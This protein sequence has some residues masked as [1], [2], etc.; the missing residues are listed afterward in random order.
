[1]LASE[2]ALRQFTRVMWYRM[3]FLDEVIVVNKDNANEVRRDV[4]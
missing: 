3:V 1:M 2:V 4:T